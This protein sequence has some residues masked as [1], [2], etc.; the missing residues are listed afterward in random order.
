MVRMRETTL[1]K[2]TTTRFDSFQN[3]IRWF[4]YLHIE[5]KEQFKSKVYQNV[6]A[7]EKEG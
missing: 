3:F 7:S 2:H 6:K 4:S 5:L 1:E